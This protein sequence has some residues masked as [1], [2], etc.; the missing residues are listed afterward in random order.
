MRAARAGPSAGTTPAAPWGECLSVKKGRPVMWTLPL[1]ILGT[2]F[3][4][5]IPLGLMMTWIFDGHY[6]PPGW[7]RR[8]E[9][10]VDTGPQNWKQYCWAFLL[11]NLVTLIVGFAVLSLQPWLPLNPDH[12]G[13][14]APTTIFNT[15]ISFMT[16]TNLQHYAGEVH[17]SYFSQLFF[18]CWKQFVTPSI[19]LAALL[20]ITRGLRGDADMGNF[21]VDVWRGVAYVF[22][23]LCLVLA[24]LLMASG[25]PMTLDGAA[26]AQ[27]LQEGAMGTD[28]QGRSVLQILARGP[29][30]AI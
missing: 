21:Y 28:D 6:H 2:T 9:S 7:L 19:G 10:W 22:L 27:P 5:A 11:F 14:L 4:L 12:K 29:V 15:A 8:V 23:P 30:A 20:A 24:V 26:Q 25:V 16:N 17:L 1:L 18:I 13:M 3:V